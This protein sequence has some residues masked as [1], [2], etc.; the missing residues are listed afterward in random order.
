MFVRS[1]TWTLLAIVA[2][3]ILG[4]IQVGGPAGW[5]VSMGLLNIILSCLCTAAL[6]FPATLMWFGIRGRHRSQKR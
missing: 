2:V 6:V 4:T 1:I 3:F 5:F